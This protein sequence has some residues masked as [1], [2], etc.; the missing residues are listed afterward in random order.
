MV[1]SGRGWLGV[2]VASLAGR[3]SCTPSRPECQAGRNES[4]RVNCGAFSLQ[5]IASLAC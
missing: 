3:G 2:V 1:G 4:V 5:F